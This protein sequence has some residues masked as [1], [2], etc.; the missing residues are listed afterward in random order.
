MTQPVVPTVVQ[1]SDIA[2]AGG[3]DAW[4]VAELTRRGLRDSSD[5]SQMSD[6]E[7]KNF[8]AKREEERKVRRE[9]KKA[10]WSAYRQAHIV[11]VGFPIF[12]HDT[13]DVDRFDVPEAE[14]RL[15]VNG[16]PPMKD[17]QELAKLLELTIP[18]LRWLVFHREVDSGT[19]YRRWR[20]PKRSGGERLISAPKHDLKR[21]QSFIAQN[22]VE[23]LPVHGLVHGFL[24]GRSI[25]TNALVHARSDVVVKLDLEDF[26]P[27]ITLPRVKGMFR[28]AGY[29][30]Q[31]ATL[32]ALLCTESP[33][34]EMVIRGKTFYVATGPR[35]LPQGA[36]T[37]PSITNAICLK[38]DMRLS[39]LARKMGV[40]YTRYADDL[41]FSWS[42]KPKQENAVARLL[43]AVEMVANEEGFKVHRKKTR[44]MRKGSRQSVTGLVVNEAGGRPVARVPR[45]YVRALRAAIKNR[46][47]GRPG[48]GEPLAVLKGRAAHVF[49][50]DPVKGRAF[51][52]R[53]GRLEAKNEQGGDR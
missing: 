12:Y 36:P 53:I 39:G 7:R 51:L 49:M 28:K 3:V 41:T 8:K 17:A 46:E 25:R 4:I 10:T 11:H 47:L 16:L 21:V 29:G 26:Y 27:S 32:L 6:S 13:V 35:S 23:H 5:T 34:D 1:W 52:E 15:K 9:L 44:V 42:G 33:R 24:R 50:A 37:S 40:A 2:A 19:H 48:Q 43:R 18:R 38:L 14:E 45:E 30:E 31:V 22:I 20:I